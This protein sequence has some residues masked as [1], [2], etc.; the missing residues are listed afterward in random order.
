MKSHCVEKTSIPKIVN[1]VICYPG[2]L[3]ILYLDSGG[4]ISQLLGL[5]SYLHMK[6]ILLQTVMCGKH[7]GHYQ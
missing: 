1:F 6:F 7:F 2:Y 4:E 5:R 3:T